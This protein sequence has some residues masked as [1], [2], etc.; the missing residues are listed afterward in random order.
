MLTIRSKYI[1]NLFQYGLFNSIWMNT[2]KWKLICSN[3]PLLQWM[4]ELDFGQ[5]PEKKFQELSYLHYYI[6]GKVGLSKIL[7]WQVTM[8]FNVEEHINA[9][10]W[11][12]WW[13]MTLLDS[14]RDWL[15]YMERKKGDHHWSHPVL[16]CDAPVISNIIKSLAIFTCLS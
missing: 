10:I 16:F 7:M 3:C 11:F 13:N 2:N 6:S 8:S 12:H 15:Q 4:Y 14:S 9:L 1:K 5:E